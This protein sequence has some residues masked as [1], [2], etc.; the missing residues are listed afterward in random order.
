MSILLLNIS[1][2]SSLESFWRRKESSWRNDNSG[3]LSLPERSDN[4]IKINIC[5]E[6]ENVLEVLS[7]VYHKKKRTQ[8]KERKHNYDEHFHFVK[9]ERICR[10]IHVQESLYEIIVFVM[11]SRFF[12]VGWLKCKLVLKFK[13]LKRICSIRI[14]NC[15]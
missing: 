15:F 6:E 14:V 7:G 5:M 8:I 1:L 3:L 2:N 10:R 13:T 9:R 4:Q 12:L 11:F